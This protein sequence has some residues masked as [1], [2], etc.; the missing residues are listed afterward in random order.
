MKNGELFVIVEILLI[1]IFVVSAKF[2]LVLYKGF[3]QIES[4]KFYRMNLINGGMSHS[5]VSNT[6]PPTDV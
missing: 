4:E 2:S 5:Y 3:K 6:I 1:V